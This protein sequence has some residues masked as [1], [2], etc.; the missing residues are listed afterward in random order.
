MPVLAEHHLLMSVGAGKH[1]RRSGRS[2]GQ[3]DRRRD[4]RD[5]G[6]DAYVERSGEVRHCRDSLILGARSGEDVSGSGVSGGGGLA[7]DG[8]A[9]DSAIGPPDPAN[10]SRRHGHDSPQRC[11]T[12]R[13]T[14]RRGVDPRRHGRCLGNGLRITHFIGYNGTRFGASNHQQRGR[15]GRRER[16]IHGWSNPRPRASAHSG[17]GRS[18]VPRG[19]Q[20]RDS[21]GKGGKVELDPYA[22][23][24]P[25]LSR[26]GGSI[27]P[28]GR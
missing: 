26:V 3:C 24:A 13:R 5:G 15:C 23:R 12:R 25:A 10:P 2:R 16:I 20:D 19:P 28:R 14:G 11:R 22:R 7:C 9:S 4:V 18:D 1:A 6:R 27:A 17:G 8:T 21:V